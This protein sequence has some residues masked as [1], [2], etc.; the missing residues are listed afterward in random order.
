MFPTK[1][2]PDRHYAKRYWP[3]VGVDPTPPDIE[4]LEYR[5]RPGRLHYSAANGAMC[6][7][8]ASG[9]CGFNVDGRLHYGLDV[10][11]M[12][13]TAPRDEP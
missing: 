13:F 10:G 3:G 9:P 2:F 1:A 7:A 8:A 12:H 11:R 6:F 4:G 5:T